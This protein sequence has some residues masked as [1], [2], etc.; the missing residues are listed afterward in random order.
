MKYFL[1]Y[2]NDIPYMAPFLWWL[3]FEEVK[4]FEHT[5]KKKTSLSVGLRIF[6]RSID[7]LWKSCGRVVVDVVTPCRLRFGDILCPS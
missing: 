3:D 6:P 5:N 1:Q 4:D 2:T 7:V